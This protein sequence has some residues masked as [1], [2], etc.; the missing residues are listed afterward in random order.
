MSPERKRKMQ[1]TSTVLPEKA[2][3]LET[4]TTPRAGLEVFSVWIPLHA[5][6]RRGPL[7]RGTGT[8]LVCGGRRGG[9]RW[10]HQYFSLM[11]FMISLII[12]YRLIKPTSRSCLVKSWCTEEK[13]LLQSIDSSRSISKLGYQSQPSPAM[14]SLPKAP[15]P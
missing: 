12:R 9:K 6:P 10:S 11:N 1:N 15:V 5:H 13:N 8:D 7:L 3:L 14:P 4:M 2:A